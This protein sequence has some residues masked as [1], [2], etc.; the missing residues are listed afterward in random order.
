MLECPSYILEL[1]FVCNVLNT[2][3]PFLQI[4]DMGGLW[5]KLA[6]VGLL[7]VTVDEEFGGNP[8]SYFCQ[9]LMGEEVARAS[10][11]VAL[12]MGAHNNLCA[13]QLNRHGT[14]EQKAKYLTRMCQ[15]EIIGALAMS[16]A[17]SGSDV[18]SMKT[19]SVQPHVTISSIKHFRL[20]GPRKMV[21]TTY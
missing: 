14:K 9:A 6:S 11:A 21:T 16:E 2:N 15:G 1:H 4:P 12:S 17:G 20:I 7:G 13:L 3:R 19:R 5:K 10:A 18:V 8:M